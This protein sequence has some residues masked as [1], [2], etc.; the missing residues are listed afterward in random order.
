[1]LLLLQAL[2]NVHGNSATATKLQTARTISLSGDVTGS[3]S[4][5]GSANVTITT[6]LA[7]VA[8]ATGTVRVYSSSDF[9]NG[10]IAYPS[11]FN[12][13]NCIPISVAIY[14]S[15]DSRWDFFNSL[16][17]NLTVSLYSSTISVTINAREGYIASGTYNV[18]VM[19]MKI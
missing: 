14:N 5:N 11:G 1:M 18:K 16:Y 19:L 4:F 10:N 15:T 17:N 7:N 6:N 9:G 12:K 2:V 8:V 13:D 3:A